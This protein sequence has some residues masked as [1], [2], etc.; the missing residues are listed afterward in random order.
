MKVEDFDYDLPDELI[1]QY[2]AERREKSRMIV[3]DRSKEDLR[4]TM[5]GNFP[6]YLQEGD[7]L[8]INETKVIPA[9][10]YGQKM[11]GGRVEIFLVRRLED[12]IWTAMV[13]PSRRV[14]PGM[15][16]Y[17]GGE[18]LPIEILGRLARGEWKVALPK[19]MSERKFID[20]FGHM[21]LPP[22]IKRA[23]EEEDRERYQTVFARHEG[24]VA[25][26]TAG[27]H[28]SEHLLERIKM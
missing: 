24:S 9:R 2:P 17:V 1:A 4:E 7:L 18:Q 26:P 8:V 12:R 20:Q 11:S 10:L 19:A 6:R 15:F 28:F 16:I 27:L 23:D 21:P 5:F 25:A 13:R 22:Y 3:L 14:R